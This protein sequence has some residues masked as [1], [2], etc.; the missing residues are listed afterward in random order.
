M[1]VTFWAGAWAGRRSWRLLE[2][3]PASSSPT[4][5]CRSSRLWAALKVYPCV[6]KPPPPA[7]ELTT[8]VRAWIEVAVR[9]WATRGRLVVA[10]ADVLAWANVLEPGTAAPPPP[11]GVS[12]DGLG[13][14]AAAAPRATAAQ[15][16]RRAADE[17]KA[18]RARRKAPPWPR[19]GFKRRA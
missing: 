3:C 10:K 7:L 15:A 16:D 2:R 9:P 6:L 1:A 8:S 12:R 19:D 5:H 14:H 11:P 18:G 13:P 17:R 4:R